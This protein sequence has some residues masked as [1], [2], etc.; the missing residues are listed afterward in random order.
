MYGYSMTI[1]TLYEANESAE[2]ATEVMTS[3]YLFGRGE[4][5]II[6]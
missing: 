1:Y 4:R 6:C 2:P 3:G 5:N